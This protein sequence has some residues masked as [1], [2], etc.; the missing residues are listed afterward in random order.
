MEDS[1]SNFNAKLL[2]R[3]KPHDT[4]QSFNIEMKMHS[5]EYITVYLGTSSQTPLELGK[6][7][8]DGISLL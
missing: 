7:R 4:K 1:I 5:K 2:K 3:T 6:T 8:I